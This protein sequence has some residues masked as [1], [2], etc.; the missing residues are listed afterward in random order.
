[1]A[2]KKNT[3]D[4]VVEESFKAGYESEPEITTEETKSQEQPETVIEKKELTVE[5]INSF[6]ESY[7]KVGFDKA[8]AMLSAEEQELLWENIQSGEGDIAELLYRNTE[9][10]T[11]YLT[12]LQR[13]CIDIVSHENGTTKNQVIVDALDLYFS[14]SVIKAAKELII[15]RTLKKVLRSESKQ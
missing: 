6:I 11:Y 14:E 9:R 7:N 1:M 15:T 12:D 13:A 4:N 3:F 5:E 2:K 10:S 8:L